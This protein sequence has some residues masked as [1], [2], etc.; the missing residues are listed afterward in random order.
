M[1][2]ARKN[3][4]YRNEKSARERDDFQ[5]VVYSLFFTG[6]GALDLIRLGNG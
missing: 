3:F 4:K 1:V 5:S 6:D 2:C